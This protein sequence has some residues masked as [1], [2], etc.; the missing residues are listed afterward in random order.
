MSNISTLNK[1]NS[2]AS[3]SASNVCEPGKFAVRNPNNDPSTFTCYDKTKENLNTAN[4]ICKSYGETGNCTPETTNCNMITNRN[5]NKFCIPV[6]MRQPQFYGDL[7]WAGYASIKWEKKYLK[8]KIKY[9]QL[10][11]KSNLN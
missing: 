6:G 4:F 2:S 5:G 10:K 7:Q 8:Y 9:Q 1:I 3:Y 11:S